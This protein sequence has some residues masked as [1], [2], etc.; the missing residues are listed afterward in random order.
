MIEKFLVS[1]LNTIPELNGQCYPVAAPVGDL[2]LLFC[3]YTRVSGEIVRDLSGEPVFYRDVYRLDLCEEDTDALFALE[4]VVISALAKTNVA[5]EEMYI[6]SAD[7]A[8]GAPD[9][10]DLTIET[11]LRSITYTVTYWR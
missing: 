9:G 1:E 5:F 4:Q 6:F 7:A 3:I 11:T 10:F 2:D 8:P